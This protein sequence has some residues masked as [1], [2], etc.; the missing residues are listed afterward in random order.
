MRGFALPFIVSLLL[1]VAGCGGT[2]S[3][4]VA[5]PRQA[6][7]GNVAAAVDDEIVLPNDRDQYK[8]TSTSAGYTITS[9]PDDGNS[10]TYPVLRRIQFADSSIALDVEKSSTVYRLYQAAFNRK[11]DLGGLG[12]WLGALDADATLEQIAE[13]FISSQEFQD[14]YATSTTNQQ[15]IAKLYNNVLHRTPDAAG[16]DY[17][18]GAFQRGATKIAVLIEFSESQENKT[19]TAAAVQ[20]G[21]LYLQTGIKYRPVAVVAPDMHTVVG[22]AV[23]L[24]GSASTDANDDRLSFT[25]LLTAKP[26]TSKVVLNNTSSSILNFTPDV[27]G[28]YDAPLRVSDGTLTSRPASSRVTATAATIVVQIPDSGIYKCAQLSSAQAAALYAAGHGYLDRD[29]DGKPCEANDI[30]VEI[31]TATPPPTSSAGKQC[32]VNGYTRKNG[33]YVHGYWRRC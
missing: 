10:K 11:P 9:I 31:A 8:I 7:G 33:T 19:S 18:L 29:H 12:Y 13:S 6:Q 17:W 32:W 1:I 3:P 25:W 5:S 2:S 15:F 28:I 30:L 22:T 20:D 27:A 16:L 24:D 23:K 21:I 4:E 14:L 26:A